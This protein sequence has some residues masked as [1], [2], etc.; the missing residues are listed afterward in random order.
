LPWNRFHFEHSNELLGSMKNKEVL[1]M[2]NI[3]LLLK[4]TL[5]TWYFTLG[6]IGS[7]L[8]SYLE[9]TPVDYWPGGWIHLK[10]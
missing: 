8:V 6:L 3:I 4:G 9:G 5:A 7:M 2:L 10:L 1:C